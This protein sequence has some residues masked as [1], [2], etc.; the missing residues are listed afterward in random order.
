[1]QLNIYLCADLRCFGRGENTSAGTTPWQLSNRLFLEQLDQK[2]SIFVDVVL[3]HF[4]S[5][6]QML[7]YHFCHLKL[8]VVQKKIPFNLIKLHHSHLNLS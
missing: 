6:V 1:M 8:F 4:S 2:P 5:T 7:G 3:Q